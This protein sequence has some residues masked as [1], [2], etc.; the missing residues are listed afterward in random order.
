MMVY[1]ISFAQV[2]KRRWGSRLQ[3]NSSAI[4][5]VSAVLIGLTLLVSGTGK[6]PG[7]T[8]FI[9]LLLKSFWTPTIAYF[10]GYSLPWLEIGLGIM[11]LLGLFPRIA[12]VLCLPLIGGFIANNSWALIHGVQEFPTC[13]SCFGM[14]EEFLGS[15]SPLGAL[16]LD[17]V[18]LCLAFIV[19]L[20]HKEG[21]LT[22]RPWFIKRKK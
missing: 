11:L 5:I 8:E 22:F 17:I 10:I 16:I 7:Q 14:W 1:R 13:A 4:V 18:L 12:A 9:F 2:M 20:S 15:L 6:L 19:L 3:K 21:F